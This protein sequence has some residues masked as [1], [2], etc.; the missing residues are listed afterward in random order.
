M[1]RKGT[2]SGYICAGPSW[3]LVFNWTLTLLMKMLRYIYDQLVLVFLFRGLKRWFRYN[4][5]NRIVG[6]TVGTTMILLKAL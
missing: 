6:T 3:Q 5:I 1:Q 2:S 4:G